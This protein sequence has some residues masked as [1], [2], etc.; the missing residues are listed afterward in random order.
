MS[1]VFIALAVTLGIVFLWG[2]LAPR[3][4]WR[5]LTGWSVSDPHANE[6]GAVSYRFRRLLFAIGIL[7]MSV[8]GAGGYL[9]YLAS[10]PSPPEP[11]TAMELMWGSPDPDIVNRVVVPLAAPPAG[12]VDQPILGYQEIDEDDGPAAYLADLDLFERLG[13]PEIPGYIG[14]H[15]S[16]GYSAM[17]S[18]DFFVHLRGDLLCIPRAAV[19]IETETVVQI[20]VYYG[21]PDPPDGS[22]PDSVVA[23]SR[24]LPVSLSLLIPIEL[25]APIGDR[26]LQTLDGSAIQKV[27]VAD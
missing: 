20:A 19:V 24:E 4:Q 8:I 17:D 1:L 2:L 21:L 23:C 18:A 27:L 12:L 13:N 6:P 14:Q 5:A 15:P 7:G 3:N 22:V 25:Q 16:G 9:N 11:P 26:E 10:I